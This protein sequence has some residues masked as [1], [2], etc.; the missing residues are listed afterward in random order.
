VGRRIAISGF[1]KLQGKD[2]HGTV[3][4]RKLPEPQI[5]TCV[6]HGVRQQIQQLTH[7]SLT[8]LTHDTD[9]WVCCPKFQKGSAAE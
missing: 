4:C 8:S 9:S 2:V 7:E 5:S 3:A 6:L 1:G